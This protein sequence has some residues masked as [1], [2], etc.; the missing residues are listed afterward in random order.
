MRYL[1]IVFTIT[2]AAGLLLLSIPLTAQRYQ[3]PGVGYGASIAYN[4][5]TEGFAG[6][7]RARIPLA[8][9]FYI[10]PEADYF[11]SFNEYHEFYV[12]AA[13]QYDLFS[14]GSFNFYALGAGYYNNWLNADDFA[15]GQKK[16][17]N[18]AP[19]AGGGMVRNKGCIR[20][21]IEDRYDFKWEENHLH[22][23]IY[24]YPGACNKQEKCPGVDP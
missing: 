15:P 3:K 7:L 9:Y 16:E 1:K 11:P 8:R 2:L 4:F 12:G 22:I 10:V 5:M 21:F 17:N 23:G 14:I 18:F 6:G 19:E 24:W 20:P 13:L